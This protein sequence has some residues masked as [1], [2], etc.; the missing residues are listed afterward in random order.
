MS[1]RKRHP[2][3]RGRLI[4]WARQARPAGR[5]IFSLPSDAA[6]LSVLSTLDP[7]QFEASR[8]ILHP[9]LR[10]HA[11]AWATAAF[12][13]AADAV[14]EPQRRPG[15]AAILRARWQVAVRE[16]DAAEYAALA[17]LATG[18]SFG[19]AFDAG[20]DLDEDAP[21]AAWLDGWLKSGVVTGIWRVEDFGD[22]GPPSA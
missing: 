1:A 18:A 19:A 8:A 4:R 20:F 17:R 9:S 14:G 11:A 5:T 2:Y 3:S 7:Q 6:P 15:H 16:I 10:L 22:A 13:L 21:I 12:W